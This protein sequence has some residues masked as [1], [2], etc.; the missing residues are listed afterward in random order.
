MESLIAGVQGGANAVYLSGKAF[1]ARKFAK[2][3]DI[4][5][6]KEAVRYCHIR[7]VKV[8]VTVNTLIKDSEL[9]SVIDYVG[10]LYRADVDAIIIQDI[11][12]LNRVRE[13]Y[14][15]FECHA[16][17]QMTLQ[18]KDDLYIAKK[19]GLKRAVLPREMALKDMQ[20]IID[21]SNGITEIEAFIHGAL[22][23]SY[24]G[25]CLMSSMIG[26]RSGNRGSCAQACRKKYKLVDKNTGAIKNDKGSSYLL[27]PKDLASIDNFEKILDSSVYSYKIEGRMKGADYAYQVVSTYR[28]LIDEYEKFDGKISKES[29][30]FAKL[31]LKKVFNRDFTSGHLF[32][33]SYK[34]IA[35]LETPANKGYYIGD[36]L[37]Y[38]AKRKQ[39]KIRLKNDI[40]VGD[41]IQIRREDKS[42][43]ARVEHVFIKGEKLKSATA[44]QIIKVP[45]KYKAYPKEKIYKTFDNALAKDISEYLNKERLKIDIDML[46]TLKLGQ[47]CVL[48]ISDDRG[49]IV[50]VESGKLVEKAIK[51]PLS[52]DRIEAQ[53]SKIGDTNYSLRAC[54][55]ICDEGV[56]IP[57]KEIN[58]IRREAIEV[59][60]DKRAILNVDR[61]IKKCDCDVFDKSFE[62]V[63][64]G[65]IERYINREKKSK[66]VISVENL[67]SLKIALDMGIKIIYYKDIS[68]VEEAY[69]ICMDKDVEFCIQLNRVNSDYN[70]AK[71]NEIVN[72]GDNTS[73]I[74]GN[75]GATLYDYVKYGDYS[76]N[77]MNIETAKFYANSGMSRIH[78]SVELRLDELSNF[79]N[80]NMELEYMVFCRQPLMIMNYCPVDASGNCSSKKNCTISNYYLLDEKQAMFGLYANDCRRVEILNGPYLNLLDDINNLK[81]AGVNVFRLE[82]YDEDIKFIKRV[83]SATQKALLVDKT[84]KNDIESLKNEYGISYTT[85]H[86][87]RGVE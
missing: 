86:L 82:F 27:S 76:L 72:N 87:R 16:S 67:E 36:V 40:L 15:L 84:Y 62:N 53:L 45:F 58:S 17:T 1:G 69:K 30:S 75:I 57:I 9:H 6:I 73:A 33:D 61:V 48:Q 13:I 19:L 71:I 29:I 21:A 20:N 85:G 34:N 74:A 79:K 18:N 70:M 38:D 42:I 52:K 78:P 25:Q 56:T 54:E 8:Y 5:E 12:L 49:N 41:D 50:V 77:V 2:N 14:P 26:A 51:T 35:S 68:T 63:M 22:C 60:S 55:I 32:S 80:L 44:G 31:K 65:N 83:I 47:K 46:I 81:Q 43:G 23:V 4:E 39:L 10:K 66:L 64:D 11:G 7:D 3:F 28:D 37:E 59:L 24:S